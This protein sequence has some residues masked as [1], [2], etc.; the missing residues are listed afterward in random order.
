MIWRQEVACIDSTPGYRWCCALHIAKTYIR[1]HGVVV[2]AKETWKWVSC[3]YLEAA[4]SGTVPVTL[5]L[6]GSS[7][8]TAV[9]TLSDSSN[10]YI[11]AT[12]LQPSYYLSQCTMSLFFLVS[13][14]HD[15]Q[16]E[17]FFTPILRCRTC[18]TINS[19]R[20]CS[21]TE[22]MRTIIILIL[23]FWDSIHIRDHQL[24]DDFWCT[25]HSVS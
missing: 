13:W 18:P 4:S 10:N 12:L 3:S 7:A 23:T 9:L 15:T 19:A 2:S 1:V 17:K 5:T 16:L 6:T 11:I 22:S 8:V 25:V 14:I 20:S 24:H 21:H